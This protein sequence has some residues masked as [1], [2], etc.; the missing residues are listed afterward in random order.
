MD[1]YVKLRK[2]Y[3]ENRGVNL[4]AD[5]V[6]K[7]IL[8]DTAVTEI[9]HPDRSALHTHKAAVRLRRLGGSKGGTARAAKLTPEQ[10]SAIASKAA[11]ARWEAY[12]DR[13][14][15][16]ERESRMLGGLGNV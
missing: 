15:E 3:D 7:L 10:R 14:T 8:M 11:K 9:T 13:K 12:E 1:V 6:D 2:A 5:D 16:D 4:T